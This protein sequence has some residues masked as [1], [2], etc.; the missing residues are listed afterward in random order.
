[1]V[2]S[3]LGWDERKARANKKPAVGSL[4]SCHKINLIEMKRLQKQPNPN[5]K[6]HGGRWLGVEVVEVGGGG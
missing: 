3:C 5:K 4:C 1:M 6:K 2:G